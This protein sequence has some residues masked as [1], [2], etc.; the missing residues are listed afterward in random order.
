VRLADVEGAQKEILAIVRK[1][2][3]DGSIT[4]AAKAETFV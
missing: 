4:L 2:A 3:D 1:M